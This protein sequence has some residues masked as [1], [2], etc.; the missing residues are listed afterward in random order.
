M[1]IDESW[2]VLGCSKKI[3]YKKLTCL[4]SRISVDQDRTEE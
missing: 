3:Y 1:E 4:S 2:D